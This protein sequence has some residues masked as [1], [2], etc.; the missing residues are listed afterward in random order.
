MLIDIVIVIV[1]DIVINSSCKSITW[2]GSEILYS[3]FIT[4]LRY[5]ICYNEENG[6]Q[7]F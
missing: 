4:R 3:N 1:I 7:L 2:S 6:T 5:H